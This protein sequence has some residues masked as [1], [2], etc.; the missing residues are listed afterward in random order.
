MQSHLPRCAAVAVFTVVGASAPTAGAQEFNEMCGA[1]ACRVEERPIAW[2]I[3]SYDPRSRL[4]EIGWHSGGC[5]RGDPRL[6]VGQGRARIEV[7]VLQDVV[8][9][10]DLP[11]PRPVCTAEL[12]SGVVRAQLRRALAGRTVAG[13]GRSMEQ[14][15]ATPRRIPSVVDLSFADAADTLRS[16]GFEVRRIGPRSGRVRFQSPMPGKRAGGRPV[17]L[18]TGLWFEGGRLERCLERAGIPTVPRRPGW[19]GD[20]DAPDL[21]LWLSL[22][23]TD[24]LRRAFVAFYADPRRAAENGAAIE[25]RARRSGHTVDRRRHTTIVWVRPPAAAERTA[26]GHCVHGPAGRRQL[27]RG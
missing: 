7:T 2:R 13:E 4:L 25:R 17:T 11:D 10:F 3:A 14:V 8:V 19:P 16:Q 22:S 24:P 15:V 6:V 26:V 23:D 21:V 27:A 12:R 9:A 18:T 20:L 1:V 5:H